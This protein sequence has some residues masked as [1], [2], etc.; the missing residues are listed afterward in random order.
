MGLFTPANAPTKPRMPVP[1]APLNRGLFGSSNR[2]D[3][4]AQL[5]AKGNVSTL[6][7]IVTQLADTTS[8]L[9]WGL[10]RK[11]DENPFTIEPWN[12]REFISPDAHPAARLWAKP[13]RFQT[14]Q[15]LVATAQQHFELTGEAW[16]AIGRSPRSKMP[17]ELW[18][19]RPDRIEVIPS[20]TEFIAGYVYHGPNGEKVPLSRDDVLCMK[21]PHPT[22]PYR[23]MGAVQTIMAE[24]DASNLSA[25]W[26]QNFF[27]NNAMPSGIIELDHGLS[28]SQFE[29]FSQRWH[30]QHQGTSRAG[31]VGI[32]E[33]GKW[34]DTS[35]SML[36]MQFIEN[37]NLNRDII[38][39]AFA[40]PKS[41]LGVSDD[42]NRATADAQSV[43]YAR[44][45]VRPRGDKWRSLLNEKLLPKFGRFGEGV[46]FEYPDPVADDKESEAKVLELRAK[47]AFQLVDIGFAPDDVTNTTQLP[48]MEYVGRAA[49]V[50]SEAVFIT[51][52]GPEPVPVE[53]VEA[54][55]ETAPELETEPQGDGAE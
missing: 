53:G 49:K 5:K 27:R 3:K 43:N 44:D 55:D 52:D 28:D 40:Y 47:S 35:F 9:Q 24:L 16:L 25:E 21:N 46:E 17:L 32:L 15:E 14:R 10:F 11:D 33:N 31:T 45:H 38:R 30:D 4:E 26:N 1:Y 37:R 39:E 54:P 34:K 48:P 51:E 12:R 36:D 2:T 13:N 18:T 42:V 50:G 7:A 41:K 20:R 22:D 6:F 19:I 8:S 23:G 29:E